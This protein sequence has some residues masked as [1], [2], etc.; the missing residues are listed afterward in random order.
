[1]VTANLAGDLEHLENGFGFGNI[2]EIQNL[3]RRFGAKVA[4]DDVSFHVPAGSVVGLVG[5]NGA[6]KTTLIKHILGLLKAQAG[7]VRVFGLDPVKEPVK[8]LSR[9]GYLSEEPDMPGWMRVHE[10]LRYIAAFYP[11]W[12]AAYAEEL[13]EEFELDPKAKIKQLSKG[14]RARAGLIIALAYRPELLLLD[15]PSSGLDPI[16]RR[17]I[18]GAIIRTIAD[19][20]RTVLFSSHL[21]TEVERV[22]DQVAMIR[23]G[24]ILFCDSM[25]RIKQTHARL[26]LRFENPQITP[27]Y[28]AGALSWDGAGCE[29]TTVCS[30]HANRLHDAVEKIGARIVAQTGVSLDEIFLARSGAASGTKTHDEN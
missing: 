23:S 13:R 29:W 15:E 12:D 28:L 24:R 1:M 4:L 7:S 22:S 18:L 11:T 25:E 27:P 14:Q 20:G 2:V 16:V 26:T 30:G 21:L 3:T 6:G 17:D 5:E 10:L 9:I 8:V 19:E